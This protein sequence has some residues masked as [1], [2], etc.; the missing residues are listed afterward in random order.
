MRKLNIDG[1]KEMAFRSISCMKSSFNGV[2]KELSRRLADLFSDFLGV[3]IGGG[4][5]G[6]EVMLAGLYG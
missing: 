3:G 6:G 4:A 1:E 2:R 5:L